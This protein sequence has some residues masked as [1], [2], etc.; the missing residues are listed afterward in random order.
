MQ[1]SLK[2]AQILLKRRPSEL[3]SPLSVLFWRILSHLRPVTNHR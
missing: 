2:T 1:L 3:I